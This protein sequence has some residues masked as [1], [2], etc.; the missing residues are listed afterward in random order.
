[1]EQAKNW[2]IAAVFVLAA[3]AGTAYFVLQGLDGKACQCEAGGCDCDETLK[4]LERKI[5]HLHEHVKA[6]GDQLKVR[7]PVG[8]EN[9]FGDEGPTP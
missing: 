9:P 2:F 7:R 1:M 8:Q 3:C 4:K 5:N 6:I